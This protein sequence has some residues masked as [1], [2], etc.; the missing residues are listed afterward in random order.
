MLIF[1]IMKAHLT[2]TVL[3]LLLLVF[4]WQQG[5]MASVATTDKPIRHDRIVGLQADV[6]GNDEGTL[7]DARTL[8]RTIGSRPWRV[9]PSGG[10]RLSGGNGPMGGAVA[11]VV[12]H[13][14]Q[15]YSASRDGMRSEQMPHPVSASCQY[16]V[17]AL[18]HI[19]R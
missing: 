12:S 10:G 17:I 9:Q 13:I 19:L 2:K 1:A 3:L 6:P 8:C 14:H 18:R 5:A 7:T 15:R 11:S 16:Y 4:G